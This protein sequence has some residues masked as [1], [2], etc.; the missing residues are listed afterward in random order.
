MALRFS[1]GFRVQSSKLAMGCPNSDPGTLNSE[2][3]GYHSPVRQRRIDIGR[4]EA[5]TA[6]TLGLARGTV[7]SRTAR[8]LDR[9]RSELA[10]SDLEVA[11][12]DE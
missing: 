12:G 8:A 6:T 11:I 4:G 9:L 1:S 10:G 5:E 7:K 3:L 2:L